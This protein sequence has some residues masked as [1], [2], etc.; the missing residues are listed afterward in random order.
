MITKRN[1]A[2]LPT[3]S[4]PGYIDLIYV[5]FSYAIRCKYF[6][7]FSMYAIEC[8]LEVDKQDRDRTFIPSI[9]LG[10]VSIYFKVDLLVLNTFCFCVTLD[11]LRLL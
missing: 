1:G 7:S 4:T 11:L 6:K 9:I 2:S 3:C 5:F 10:I 8:L